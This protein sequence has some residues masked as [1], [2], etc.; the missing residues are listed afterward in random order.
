MRVVLGAG[1]RWARRTQRRGFSQN[2]AGIPCVTF[3]PRG[4][5]SHKEDEY[6]ELDTVITAAR[7]YAGATIELL[8]T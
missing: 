8:G 2:L 6:V 3:G 7:V 5:G 1:P 4:W